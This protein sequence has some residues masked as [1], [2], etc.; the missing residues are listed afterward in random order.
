MIEQFSGFCP[1]SLMSCVVT[2][3]MSRDNY[4]HGNQLTKPSGI[5]PIT[6]SGGD[7]RSCICIW[8][9]SAS[10]ASSQVMSLIS[11]SAHLSHQ[12]GHLVFP[13]LADHVSV[14][15]IIGESG[16]LEDCQNLLNQP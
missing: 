8:V 6:S 12:T 11:F 13:R 14:R 10:V 15:R 7:P 1:S 2:A 4:R 3:W 16:L 9:T 5:S